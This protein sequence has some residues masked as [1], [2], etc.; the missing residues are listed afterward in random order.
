[1]VRCLRTPSSV[2]LKSTAEA[3]PHEPERLTLRS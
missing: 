3:A 1:M 2:V